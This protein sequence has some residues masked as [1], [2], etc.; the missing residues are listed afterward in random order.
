MTDMIDYWGLDK[1]YT[2]YRLF[3]FARILLW[4]WLGKNI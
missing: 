3:I 2:F 4:E 1:K